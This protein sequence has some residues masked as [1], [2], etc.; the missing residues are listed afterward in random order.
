MK[1]PICASDEI[2]ESRVRG[3]A[4]ILLSFSPLVRFRCRNCWYR[5][6][7][8]RNRLLKVVYLTTFAVLA[9]G[10]CFHAYT[11]FVG[12]PLIDWKAAPGRAALSGGTVERRAPSAAPERAAGPDPAT[13]LKKTAAPVPAAGAGYVALHAL[14]REGSQVVS[15]IAPGLAYGVIHRQGDWAVV[16][17]PDGRLGWAK[18]D[19][20][21]G[22]TEAGGPQ[23]KQEPVL[24]EKTESGGIAVA[25]GASREQPDPRKPAVET[26][27]GV[28]DRLLV[29]ADMGRVRSA[30]SPKAPVLFWIL[31]NE[32]VVKQAEK[33]DWLRV[34]HGSGWSGWARKRLF[35]GQKSEQRSMQAARS[36]P[37]SGFSPADAKSADKGAP[38]PGEGKNEGKA[39]R[40]VGLPPVPE[41]PGQEPGDIGVRTLSV[42]VSRGRVRAAPSLESPVLAMLKRSGSVHVLQKQG[43]WFQVAA[44]GGIRGWAHGSLFAQAAGESGRPGKPAAVSAPEPEARSG[45]ERNLKVGVEVGLVRRSPS[46]RGQ[47]MFRLY[48]NEVVGELEARGEWRRIRRVNGWIGWAHESVFYPDGF[49]LPGKPAADRNGQGRIA[50]VGVDVG[51]VHEAPLLKAPRAFRVVAKMKVRVLEEKGDWLRI[52]MINGWT[53]WAH[54]SLF[55]GEEPITQ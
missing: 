29:R 8:F 16:R 26:P 28:E 34:L 38:L 23:Q 17:R 55:V 10:A 49:H 19:E 36:G 48:G 25:S 9:S 46:A 5:F 22:E 20:L 2:A 1:C 18:G 12:R 11:L 4:R 24:P 54:R 27:A 50:T 33:G 6:W 7:G 15:Y 30:P 3:G 45:P 43:A 53:G 39:A 37:D 32:T 14:P 41:K 51:I 21:A 44:E 13:A 31:K 35:T 42:A 47:V 40:P 52:R